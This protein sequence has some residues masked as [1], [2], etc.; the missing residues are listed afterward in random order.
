MKQIYKYEFIL[1]LKPQYTS[2]IEELSDFIKHYENLLKEDS[3]KP[4]FSQTYQ[5]EVFPKKKSYKKLKKSL[6]C[7]PKTDRE[8]IKKTIKMI[9]NKITENNYTV[10]IETLVCEIGKF[11][12]ADILTILV[13]EII[14]KIIFDSSFHD[15][16]I[17]ICQRIATMKNYYENLIT[18]T[19]DDD[20]KL[21]W[22]LNTSDNKTK[23]NGPFESEEEIRAYTDKHINFKYYLLNELQNQFKKK[24]EYIEE[25]KNDDDEQRYRSRRRIFAIIEFIGKLY[26]KKF[27][28][29]IIVH[30]CFLE[31]LNYN[32]N[33]QPPEE[34][35]ESFSILWRITNINNDYLINQYLQCINN[36]I[37]NYT[38][39]MRI[40]FMMED[41]LDS[42]NYNK[43]QTQ[44]F[45]PNDDIDDIIYTFKTKLNYNET[46][47]LLQ[48]YKNYIPNILQ[49]IIICALEDNK[50]QKNYYNLI[51]KCSFI[52]FNDI[53]NTIYQI[54]NNIDDVDI[55]YARKNLI[56]FIILFNKIHLFRNLILSLESS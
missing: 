43:Q 34:Y 18:I 17:K 14:S 32:K 51:T 52:P 46:T 6:I 42:K 41:I 36:L 19:I 50:N 48:K 35:I 37:K 40:E 25:S 47:S 45:N 33:I 27:I 15:I 20:N 13:D 12:N 4:I 39:P 29:E 44:K 3:V 22:T 53:L 31:L 16:Y 2:E 21:Y 8:I 28:N 1:S 49:S 38:W 11:N 24:D 9:L 54:G 10:L 56:S 23:L 26:Q 55:P 5:Y 30:L 7:K